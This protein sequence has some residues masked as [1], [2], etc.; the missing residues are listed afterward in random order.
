[1]GWQMNDLTVA[2]GGTLATNAPFGYVFDAQGTQHVNYVGVD[3]HLHE[4]LGN[5]SG[6][7]DNDLTNAAAAP[8][9]TNFG[10]GNTFLCSQH[11]PFLGDAPGVAEL[12][13]D[14]AGWHFND[15]TTASGGPGPGATFTGR[16]IGYAF[17]GQLTQHVNFPDGFGH[18]WEYWRDNTGWHSNDLTLAANAPFSSGNPTGYVFDAQGTQHVNYVGQDS[19]VHELWWDNRG[20]HHNDLTNATGAPLAWPNRDTRGYVL[21]WQGT[22]HVTYV[23]LDNHIHELWWDS[24]GWHHN[25]LT[26]ATGAPDSPANTPI[27]YVF[28]G[29][30]HVNYVGAD[31]HVHEL[32]WSGN[33]WQHSDL[34]SI[35]GAPAPFDGDV[36]G[37]AFEAQGTQHVNYQDVNKH[38][39]EL[40]WTPDPILL[41]HV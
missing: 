12:W 37:Y 7:Q 40:L 20:W 16:A 17:K 28:A 31:N 35:T 24:S 10:T 34:T 15:L 30:Q 25:D 33:N 19:H 27:G 2:T 22:Q 29:T 26:S 39:I 38:V 4:L 21:P 36:A 11:L 9:V 18:V 8:T 23:G 3:Y 14:A 6:W 5:A 13:W 32:S 1:M 41:V